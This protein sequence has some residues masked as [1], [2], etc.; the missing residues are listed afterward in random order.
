ML[1]VVL[2][3]TFCAQSLP[4]AAQTASISGTVTDAEVGEA[5]SGVPV[6]LIGLPRVSVTTVDGRYELLGV[7]AGKYV[8]TAVA[9]GY[10]SFSDTLEVSGTSRIKRD[11]RLEPDPGDR[12]AGQRQTQERDKSL[13]HP[14]LEN[15]ETL[16]L[17]Q[18]STVCGCFKSANAILGEALRLRTEYGS[19][20]QFERDSGAVDQMG[21]LLKSWRTAQQI[22][23]TRF[24]SK[25]FEDTWCN[26]PGE[27]SEKR[28]AL[29]SLG[30]AI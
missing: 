5:I 2:W 8:L 7:E 1:G 10:V 22:C 6:Y 4:A 12:L 30:I 28:R 27:I 21:G 11:F 26:S 13:A 24:G 17:S 20:V 29:D 18:L 19:L 9:R 25:L 23:L 15:S 14:V 16:R 3:L